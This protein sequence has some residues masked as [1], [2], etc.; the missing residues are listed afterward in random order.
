[1]QRLIFANSRK[2]QLVNL[3]HRW[4]SCRSLEKSRDSLSVMK[5]RIAN[6]KAEIVDAA[7]AAELY[8]ALPVSFG[9][10]SSAA[11]GL[12]S[13]VRNLHRANHGISR[14]IL[15]AVLVGAVVAFAIVRIAIL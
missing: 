14:W 6:F 12:S 7:T 1:M 13:H 3:V 10:R 8:S 11:P 5:S 4:A 15:F 9:S 2:H